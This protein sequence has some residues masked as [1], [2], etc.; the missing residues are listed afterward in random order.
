MSSLNSG[1]SGS[2]KISLGA[3]VTILEVDAIITTLD[4]LTSA[5]GP[6]NVQRLHK[7]GWVGIGYDNGGSPPYDEVYWSE[8]INH[9][10]R[11]FRIYPL[12]IFGN[13]MFYDLF[14]GTVADIN[15]YW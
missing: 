4:S 3:S 12:Q 1:L 7:A 2:G 10:M 9:R 15:V 13:S 5:D 6:L 14:Y 8:F 11:S